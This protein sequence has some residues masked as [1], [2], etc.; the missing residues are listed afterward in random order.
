MVAQRKA[1]SAI[2]NSPNVTAQRQ[3]IGSLTG[4]TAQREEAEEPLQAKVAQREA[5][6]AKPN[7]TG[8]PDN[9]K[10]GIEN[11]SGM[12]MDNVKVHYNSSQPAQ[13]N[14]LAY[15][16]GTDIHVAPGQEQHLPHEA[17]HVVQQAQGR[18]KP[19]MQMKEGV[20]VNDDKSLEH[21][22]DV[23][24]GRAT[25]MVQGRPLSNSSFSFAPLLQRMVIQLAW[26]KQDA[27]TFVQNHPPVAGETPQVWKARVQAALGATNYDNGT[28]KDRLGGAFY[29]YHRAHVFTAVNAAGFVGGHVPVRPMTLAQYRLANGDALRQAGYL[30][31]C[32]NDFLETAFTD[33]WVGHA[34]TQ[35]NANAFFAQH[36]PEDDDLDATGYFVEHQETLIENWHIYSALGFEAVRDL[37]LLPMT[38]FRQT[39]TQSRE[40]LT[41]Y[42]NGLPVPLR[43]HVFDGEFNNNAPKGLHAYT[44][45][46]IGGNTLLET[47]GDPGGVHIVIWTNPEGAGVNKCK[48]S[49]MF[50][51]NYEQGMS[52][53][54]LLNHGDNE[55]YP[56]GDRP[57]IGLPAWQIIGVGEAGATKFPISD[58]VNSTADAMALSAHAQSQQEQGHTV[59]RWNNGNVNY[60]V[61]N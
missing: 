54:H 55:G 24:G 59:Y 3:Q 8:L 52:A 39:Q 47:L 35:N 4:E 32:S 58:G 13:L 45:R 31:L 60:R 19:T 57:T 7:N 28:D 21:E 27:D 48:W 41:E 36:P 15:A 5:A 1:I 43:T 61:S 46:G 12:S 25:Q 44:D 17:W 23:M 29:R 26:S 37:F 38:Q 34:F 10:S 51:R 14:A 50:P 16:Q 18:V 49:S 22:A 40:A 33:Y 30:L 20:P 11:L 42:Y 56:A 53:W 9:L 6:P 2:H